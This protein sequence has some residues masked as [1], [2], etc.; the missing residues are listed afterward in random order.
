[1]AT[2]ASEKPIIVVV[3]GAW[4]RPGLYAPLTDLLQNAGYKVHVVDLPSNGDPPSFAPDWTPDLRL[5]ASSV[6]SYADQG[7]NI[8]VVAHSA[9]GASATEA[10]KNLSVQERQDAGKLGG[11][12]RLVYLAAFA[13][14]LG[15]STLTHEQVREMFYWALIEDE[16]DYPDPKL[17]DEFLFTDLSP[18]HLVKYRPFVQKSAWRAR[19]H[20]NTDVT[21]VGWKHIPSS[22]LI[23]QLDKAV[24]SEMQEMIVAQE[25]SK[26]DDVLRIQAGHSPFISHAGITANFVRRA[27]GEKNIVL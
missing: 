6:E 20:A 24:P 9:G 25:G 2:S 4:C 26:F 19:Q 18:A 27:A 23:T 16:V 10:V 8:V 7:E 22:Y 12:S 14:E 1:M 5:I 21:Y 11:V 13:P 3:P 15:V 17:L